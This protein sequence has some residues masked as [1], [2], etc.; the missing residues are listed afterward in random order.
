MVE[1]VD[2]VFAGRERQFHLCFGEDRYDPVQLVLRVAEEQ[3]E[4]SVDA[5]DRDVDGLGGQLLV[6]LH[7]PLPHDDLDEPE[8]RPQVGEHEHAVDARDVALEEEG[9][10]LCRPDVVPV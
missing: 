1:W 2:A 8:D 3:T 6:D 9:L 10:E 5:D 7:D 4:E